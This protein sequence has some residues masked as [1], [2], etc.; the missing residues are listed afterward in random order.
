MYYYVRFLKDVTVNAPR[1]NSDGIALFKP[2]AG[3]WVQFSDLESATNFL[4]K[5]PDSSELVICYERT[6]DANR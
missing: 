5:Y 1:G 3:G 4:K 2:K 6:I